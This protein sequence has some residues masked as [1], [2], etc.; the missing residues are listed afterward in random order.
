M[1]S[2]KSKSKTVKTNRRIAGIP[3]WANPDSTAPVDK[4]GFENENE[5]LSDDATKSTENIQKEYL[6]LVVI[7]STFQVSAKINT[8]LVV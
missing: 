6:S 7:L 4:G 8:I 2:L 1:P 5:S 3:Q